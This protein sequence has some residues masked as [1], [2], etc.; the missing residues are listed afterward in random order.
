MVDENVNNKNANA[1]ADRLM[2][3][4]PGGLVGTAILSWVSPPFLERTIQRTP[5]A[6]EGV[7]AVELRDAQGQDI[8]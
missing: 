3:V 8:P 5:H 7:W 4:A 1:A 6:M 2:G